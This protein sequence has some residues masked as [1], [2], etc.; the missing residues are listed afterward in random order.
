M[1]LVMPLTGALYNW[2]RMHEMMAS[3]LILAV[4][5]LF[6]MV[7]FT[8]DAGMGQI[9]AA[10][11]I[12]GVGFAFTFVPVITAAVATIPRPLVHSAAGLT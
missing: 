5:G 11:V 3:G 6:R 4:I 12:Q 8:L 2:L 1:V 7:Y 10:Q 9:L